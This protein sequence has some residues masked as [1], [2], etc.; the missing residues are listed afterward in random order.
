[1]ADETYDDARAARLAA[2]LRDLAE[3]I[4]TL[5]AT[6]ALLAQSSELLRRIGDIKSELFHYEVRCTYDTPE[7]AERRR[8]VA[9]AQQAPAWEPTEWHLDD[10][11]EPPTWEPR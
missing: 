6:G 3:R 4:R 9:D 8:L 1:M 7:V 11:E 2:A 5:D 10:E